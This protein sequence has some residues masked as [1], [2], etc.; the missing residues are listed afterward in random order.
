VPPPHNPPAE[1]HGHDSTIEARGRPDHEQ[2]RAALGYLRSL[3][4]A[5]IDGIDGVAWRRPACSPPSPSSSR[6][7]A[8]AAARWRAA[9][10]IRNGEF[11][12]RH[13]QTI[14]DCGVRHR[15]ASAR[16][17]RFLTGARSMLR[18]GWCWF[19]LV[20]GSSAQ[21]NRQ[22]GKPTGPPTAP[23]SAVPD[24]RDL[25]LAGAGAAPGAF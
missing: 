18:I 5:R 22:S 17:G 9:V 25:S 12:R 13:G 14:P 4:Q 8:E 19:D 16:L 2:K 7:M 6:P 23:P 24:H 11:F 15:S 20:A 10:R 21:T 1:G 3:G